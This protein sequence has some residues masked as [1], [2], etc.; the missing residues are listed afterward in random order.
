[1]RGSNLG[2]KAVRLVFGWYICLRLSASFWGAS[3]LG[4][5]SHAILLAHIG[6][7]LQPLSREGPYLL[8]ALPSGLRPYRPLLPFKGVPIGPL[9]LLAW[10]PP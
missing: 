2:S 5:F 3:L 7:G 4:G 8:G 1:M 10:S 6:P 9:A